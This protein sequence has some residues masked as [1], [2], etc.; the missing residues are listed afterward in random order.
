[1]I[2]SAAMD[3]HGIGLLTRAF[4]IDD[5]RAGRLMQLF[6]VVADDDRGFYLVYPEI[7]ASRKKIR[8]FRDWLIAEAAP[9]AAAKW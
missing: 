2:G 6:D 4:F 8:D 3:G 1:V 7:F 9:V 5:I